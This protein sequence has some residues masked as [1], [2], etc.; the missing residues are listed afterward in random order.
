[1]WG[2]WCGPGYGGQAAVDLLD[3]ACRDHD[4]CYAS[5]GYFNCG[6]DQNLIAAINRDYNRMHTAEKIAATAVKAYF[7][8]QVKVTC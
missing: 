1:M 4:T 8:A 5:K 6:C 2:N 3:R 7:S